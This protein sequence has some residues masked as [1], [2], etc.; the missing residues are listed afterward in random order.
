MN[1]P[2]DGQGRQAGDAL[3]EMTVLDLT[4]VMAGPFCTMILADLGADVIKVEHPEAG[5]QTR[6]S[7]GRS[8]NGEDSKAF[9]ALNRNKRSITIDLKSTEGL[10]QF[11]R[12]VRSADVV[13]ENWRPGG[14]APL[15]GDYDTPSALHPPL[16]YARHS[17]L[18]Q[19]RPPAPRP[20]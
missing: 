12:L 18:R 11:H 9:L 3:A 13:G 5:D 19:T 8:G 16:G 1:G 4:Q 20:R 2:I 6:R 14:A 7:W 15:G 17:R 10:E